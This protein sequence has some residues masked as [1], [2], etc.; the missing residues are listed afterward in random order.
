MLPIIKGILMFMVLVYGAYSD[1]RTHEIP[2]TVPLVILLAGFIE[3]SPLFSIA[4]LLVTGLPFLL[5][6]LWGGNAMGGGDIKLMAACG[7]A[8]G[9]WGGILQTILGLTFAL[10]FTLI[11]GLVKGNKIDRNEQIPLA[12]FLGAGGICSYLITCIGGHLI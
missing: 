1:I 8:L 6:A 7:F 3:F 11:R 9:P 2:D 5:A 4:G 12:P 10:L